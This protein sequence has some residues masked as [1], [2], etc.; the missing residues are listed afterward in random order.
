MC[1]YMFLCLSR[2]AAIFEDLDTAC[3]QRKNT[4]LCSDSMVKVT[5]RCEFLCVFGNMPRPSL[6]TMLWTMLL[7]HVKTHRVCCFA[8]VFSFHSCIKCTRYWA[9]VA[10]NINTACAMFKTHTPSYHH[11]GGH[12]FFGRI[13]L[14]CFFMPLRSKNVILAPF[15]DPNLNQKV[16]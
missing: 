14:I 16:I 1:F 13:F 12:T 10:E 4:C 15:F 8:H 6:F 7:N 11:S 3:N 9:E 2:I 5:Q